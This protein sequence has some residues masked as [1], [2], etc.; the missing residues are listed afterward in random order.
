[1]RKPSL[2]LT[3]IMIGML[4]SVI[5]IGVFF[6]LG[7]TNSNYSSTST[8]VATPT[9]TVIPITNMT[10]TPTGTPKATSNLKLTVTYFEFSRN[11]T[12]IVI[13]FKLE[14]NSYIFQENATSFTLIA[15]G[16]KISSNLN[17]VVIIGTSYSTVYF[18]INDYNGT[19]YKMS[20]NAFPIDTIWVR[21]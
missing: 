9:P 20:S 1:M 11:Q 19:D 3:V 2:P 7:D 15:G 5:V 17:D 8:S 6:Y 4:A 14:P 21:R 10:S 12:M 16:E 18:P 13:M